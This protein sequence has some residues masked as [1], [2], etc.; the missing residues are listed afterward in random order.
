VPYTES[1]IRDYLVAFYST[2]GSGVEFEYL[3]GAEFVLDECLDCGLIFQRE[4]PNPALIERLY[5]KWLDPATVRAIVS[6]L[7]TGRSRLWCAAEIARGIEH[8]GKRPSD[9]QFLDFGM[10]WGGWCFLARGFGC[11]VY[12]MELSA[13]RVAHATASG[14]PVLSWDEL[15]NNRFDF[16]N[17]EQVFEHLA[18]PRDTLVSLAAALKP[19]G[20]IHINVPPGHDIKRKLQ[21][22]DWSLPARSPESL[23][24]VAPLQHLNCFT[25]ES[26]VR[27]GSKAGLREVE[28]AREYLLPE[29][30]ADRVRSVARPY[31]HALFPRRHETRRRM[32]TNLFFERTQPDAR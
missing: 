19:G 10:G 20:I 32:T 14:I 30:V 12:G 7:E 9:V 13:S 8:L 26:L 15:R 4:V 29:G 18:D 24:D 25:F 2:T 16:I 6:R 28:I 17:A 21:N 5:E 11:D 31:L 22:P 3:E 27:M 23:N 1:P